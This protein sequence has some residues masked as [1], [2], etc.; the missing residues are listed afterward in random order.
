VITDDNRDFCEQTSVLCNI[1]LSRTP[2]GHDK[3]RAKDASKEAV[4]NNADEQA[5]A[6]LPASSV[7]ER[8]SVKRH[9]EADITISEAQPVA[10]TG[11]FHVRWYGQDRSNNGSKE[12]T[13][14]TSTVSTTVAFV[15]NA[16]ETMH[17]IAAIAMQS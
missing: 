4:Q 12:S 5:E 8:E 1:P 3:T 9:S 17:E 6:P 15:R 7:D 16:S 11:H 13:A 10:N 2:T 14:A